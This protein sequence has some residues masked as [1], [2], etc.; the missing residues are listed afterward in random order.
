MLHKGLLTCRLAGPYVSGHLVLDY[1]FGTDI[2]SVQN[3]VGWM[4][5]LA[6]VINILPVSLAILLVVSSDLMHVEVGQTSHESD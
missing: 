5:V 1:F 4:A 2:M 6:T 3:F